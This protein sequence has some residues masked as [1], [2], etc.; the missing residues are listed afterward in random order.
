[1]MG[2]LG[3]QMFQYA[4]YKKLL[5]SGYD[6]SID[7]REIIKDGNQHNGLELERVFGVEYH[8]ITKFEVLKYYTKFLLDKLYR[9]IKKTDQGI[10]ILRDDLSIPLDT[11]LGGKFYYLSGYWQNGN[12][13]ADIR[14]AIIDDYC[15]KNIYS[16]R[17]NDD[18]IIEMENCYSISVHVRRGDY[19][20]NTDLYYICDDEYYRNAMEYFMNKYADCH[21]Y[22][23]SDDPQ[24]VKKNYS[25]WNNITIVDWNS[26]E[27]SYMD[28]YLMS[29]CKSNI[30]CA[31][32][33]SWWG[34]W[35]NQNS[36][37]EVI[38]SKKWYIKYEA[39]PAL[40][41]WISM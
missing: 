2:G 24:W 35:L 30:I 10:Y 34:A 14:N 33:F 6:V 7:D 39:N 23:F 15:F 12:Y 29:K 26:G 28:M 37:K 40:D 27:N 4:L 16:D 32:T 31:S 17:R 1:M 36:E 19:L 13:F 20:K 18:V 5:L 21:F 3:N 41:E 8:R 9:V 11:I 22:F 25:G 38:C